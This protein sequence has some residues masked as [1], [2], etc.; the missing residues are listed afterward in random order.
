LNNR[1]H[2]WK[3]AG[4]WLK[5]NM[6]RGVGLMT[7]HYRAIRCGCTVTQVLEAFRDA[8]GKVKGSYVFILNAQ[9][10]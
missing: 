8:H 9:V 1:F 3:E 10:R 4:L 2:A 6:D 5:K 7:T